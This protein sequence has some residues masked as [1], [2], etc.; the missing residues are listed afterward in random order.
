MNAFTLSHTHTRISFALLE[1]RPKAAAINFVNSFSNLLLDGLFL[2]SFSHFI[3]VICT[4]FAFFGYMFVVKHNTDNTVNVVC[5]VCVYNVSVYT[6][7]MLCLHS[8]V[9][10]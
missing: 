6:Y 2:A 3:C 8:V 7:I 5:A 1:T 9:N 4:C 10:A